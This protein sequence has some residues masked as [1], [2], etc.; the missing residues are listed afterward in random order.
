MTTTEMIST[1][2]MSKVISLLYRNGHFPPHVVYSISFSPGI[3][4]LNSQT[5]FLLFSET[6]ASI[7]MRFLT[8]WS[9]INAKQ[10]NHITIGIMSYWEV[11]I[12][13]P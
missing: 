5:S 13:F 11:Y 8:E 9:H 2:G 10:R 12:N 6:A 1:A 3:L 4:H 7:T